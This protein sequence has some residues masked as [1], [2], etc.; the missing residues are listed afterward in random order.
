MIL[1]KVVYEQLHMHLSYGF[2]VNQ[3]TELMILKLAQTFINF[4]DLFWYFL[5]SGQPL[6][7]LTISFFF[8]AWNIVDT[9]LDWLSCYLTWRCFSISIDNF[10]SNE[11]GIP[12]GVPQGSSLGPLLFNVFIFIVSIIRLLLFCLLLFILKHIQSMVVVWN[13]LYNLNFLKMWV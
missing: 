8:S 1:E 10:E 3:R 9:V 12:Y 13:V 4:L 7:L 5:T 11:F 6:I 2:R